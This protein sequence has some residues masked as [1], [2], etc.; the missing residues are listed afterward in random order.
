[1]RGDHP[2]D[3]VGIFCMAQQGVSD[4]YM[5]DW[6]SYS[7]EVLDVNDYHAPELYDAELPL[8]PERARRRG[9]SSAALARQEHLARTSSLT[10]IQLIP[11]SRHSENYRHAAGT[12]MVRLEG[13]HQAYFGPR[14]THARARAHTHAHT[15]THTHHTHTHTHTHSRTRP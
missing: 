13:D 1:M 9:M 6:A 10:G 2:V 5:T 8:W 7:V 11:R 3:D 4:I 14:Q 12:Y 15:H